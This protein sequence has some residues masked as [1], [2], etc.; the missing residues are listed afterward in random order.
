MKRSRSSFEE[1]STEYGGST[2]KLLLHGA[3]GVI[4]Y[5]TP[6]LLQK[7]FAPP[8]PHLLL[9]VAVQD[10]CLVPLYTNDDSSKPKGYEF[11]DS[12]TKDSYLKEYPHVLVPSFDWNEDD[13]R[14]KSEATDKGVGVWTL[15]GRQFLPNQSFVDLVNSPNSGSSSTP[16]VSLYDS[17]EAPTAPVPRHQQRMQLKQQK[18]EQQATERTQRWLQ[19]FISSNT[20]KNIWATV[21]FGIKFSEQKKNLANDKISGLAIVGWDQISNKKEFVTDL[22]DTK[23][24][25]A[26]LSANSVESLLQCIK[27]GADVVGTNLIKQWSLEHKAFCLCWGSSA[28][29][30]TDCILDLADKIHEKDNSPLME[31]CKCLAC[32]QKYSRAYIHHLVRAKELLAQILL[33]GH[34]LHHFLKLF[35]AATKARKDGQLQPF[36]DS[37]LQ[38]LT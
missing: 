30:S 36:V 10:T 9:G 22:L 17:Y 35:E 29:S 6:M 5:M 21:G 16:V 20:P 1:S 11:K 4:P 34:N 23:K 18:R 38:K 32:S 8:Q 27:Y 2:I 31:N 25:I 13:S 24:P 28:S 15:R 3:D 26:V 37:C 7:Y 14:K 33:M 19:E 12:W